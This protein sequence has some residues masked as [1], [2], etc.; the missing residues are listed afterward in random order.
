MNW[1]C[2][3]KCWMQ[4]KLPKLDPNVTMDVEGSVYFPRDCHLV[5]DQF[6]AGLK[7]QLALLG[8]SFQWNTE[9]TGWRVEN[10]RIVAVESTNGELNGSSTCW[11]EVRGHLRLR[12]DLNYRC[13][14]RLERGTASRWLSR[15][16]FLRFAVFLRKRGW[17]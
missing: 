7:K 15:E 13:R 4:R 6:M 11:R 9:V 12:V 8:V 1:E 17:R 2:R 10:D 3:G 5:P 16:S 14:S